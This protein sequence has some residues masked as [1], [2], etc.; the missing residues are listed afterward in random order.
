MEKSTKLQ[1]AASA[2]GSRSSKVTAIGDYPLLLVRKTG[3][4]ARRLIEETLKAI[5]EVALIPPPRILAP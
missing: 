3:A 2:V 1:P 4:N 5:V